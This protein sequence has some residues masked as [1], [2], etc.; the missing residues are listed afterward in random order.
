MPGDSGDAP[1]IGPRLFQSRATAHWNWWRRSIVPAESATASTST[2]GSVP[3]FSL[4]EA[5][6]MSNRLGVFMATGTTQALTSTTLGQV[7]SFSARRLIQLG[8]KLFFKE[9][10]ER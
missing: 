3:Q 1:P 10:A 8:V 5:L 9:G 4:R 6:S 2:I 7:T